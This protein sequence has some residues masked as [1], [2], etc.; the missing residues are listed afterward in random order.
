MVAEEA[1]KAREELEEEDR[2]AENV[3]VG[4]VYVCFMLSLDFFG[5]CVEG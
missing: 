2:Q 3:E 1:V 4:G 5:S